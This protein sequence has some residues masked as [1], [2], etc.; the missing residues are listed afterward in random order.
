MGISGIGMTELLVILVIV[1][2]LFGTKRLKTIGSD[3][4]SAIKGFRFAMNSGD[5][6]EEEGAKPQEI[7]PPSIAN[8]PPSQARAAP[9]QAPKIGD[10]DHV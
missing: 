5:R 10:R 6:D 3:L 1:M 9:D 8:S 4:G 2:L 7:I